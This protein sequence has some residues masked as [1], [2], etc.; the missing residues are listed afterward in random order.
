MSKIKIVGGNSLNGNLRIDSS[1]NACLPIFAACVLVKGKC[2][3][4]N[5]PKITDIENM[6]KIIANL[7]AIVK[8]HN[9]S[10][11]LDCTNIIN[12]EVSGEVAKQIRGSIFLLGSILGRLKKA[13][14]A[15][16]GGCSIG[17][18][19]IDL[20]IN[21]LRGLGVKINERGGFITCNGKGLTGGTV[22]LDFPS[23]GATEN[24]ILA[25]VCAKGCT[26]I[27]NAAAEPEICDLVNF[28]NKCGAKI[29]GAGSSEIHIQGV[30]ALVGCEYTPIGDRIIAGT[31]MIAVAMTGG[32]VEFSNVNFLHNQNLILKLERL[33]C[34]FAT[35]SDKIKMVASGKLQSIGN[36]QTSPYPGFATDLQSQLV[37]LL[38]ISR[39]TS[40]VTENLFESRFKFVPELNKMGAKITVSAKTAIVNG[41][42]TLVGATVSAEDLRGGAAL[43]LAGLVAHGTT[44]VE[45]AEHILRGYAKIDADLSALGA[46][47][48]KLD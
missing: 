17:T 35:Y 4:N 22:A 24:L 16:P 5:V 44:I 30:N 33:G 28:L 29:Y 36:I 14:F 42:D 2:T 45:N 46:N 32:Q 21:G 8:W 1:K 20:H 48:I 43:V 19:P 13:K 37:S 31:Y 27:I 34:T 11:S 39:G 47:I 25:A 6:L 26:K 41:V 38:S 15:F 12:Y 23:V 9:G 3:I 7:G 40:I 18:R 10:V